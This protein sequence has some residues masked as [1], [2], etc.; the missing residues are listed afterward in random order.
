MA[1]R[2][3]SGTLLLSTKEFYPPGAYRL[4]TGGI[5]HGEGILDALRREAHEETG[6]ET[7]VRRFLARIDYLAP[8]GA[9]AVFHTFAFLLDERGGTLGSLDPA[10]RISSYRE[11]RPEEL[12]E[13]ARRLEAATGAAPEIGG[14]WADW[15]RFRSVVHDA[16]ARAL[17]EIG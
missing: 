15:G 1:I 7:E 12:E 13:V 2:R 5:S 3:P 16:V 11:V 8:A 9:D 10:E 14:E 17:R 6:L 4:P